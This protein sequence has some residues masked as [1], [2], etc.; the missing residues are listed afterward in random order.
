MSYG[1]KYVWEDD[2]IDTAREIMKAENV[3]RL[4]VK[5]RA[6]EEC[7]AGLIVAMVTDRMHADWLA[8]SRWTT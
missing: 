3:R 7:V 2:T 8:F 4:V 5:K 1:A 6:N